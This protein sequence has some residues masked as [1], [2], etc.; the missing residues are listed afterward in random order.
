MKKGLITQSFLFQYNSFKH[1]QVKR[2]LL[3]MF[4]LQQ[5]QGMHHHLLKY[6][7]F[8]QLH[9]IYRSQLKYHHHQ[10]LRM[11]QIVQLQEKVL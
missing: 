10:Q 11:H 6:N 4:F 8:D 2:Q 9:Y 7:Q 1:V 5:I 3:A